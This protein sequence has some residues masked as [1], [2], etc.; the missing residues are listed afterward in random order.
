MAQVEFEAA[1]DVP[2]ISPIPRRLSGAM[3]GGPTMRETHNSSGTEDRL[4][5]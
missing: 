4:F 2:I 5:P 3:I 1:V